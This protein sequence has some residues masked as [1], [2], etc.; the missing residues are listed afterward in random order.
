LLHYYYTP[1]AARG[2]IKGMV[3]KSRSRRWLWRTL[4]ITL[5]LSGYSWWSLARPLPALQPA[6]ATL[7]LPTTTPAGHF[8]W[9]AIGQAAVGIGG[10]DRIVSHGAQKPIAMASTAKLITALAVL[11]EKPLTA[12][13]SGPVLTLTANDVALYHQYAAQ[14]GSVV[15]VA[16]GEQISE[17]QVLQAM[18]LPSSNNLSDSLAIWAFGSLSNYATY[19]NKYL[20]QLGLKHTHVGSDASGLSA[21]STTTATDL[22]RLGQIVMEQPVLKQIVAQPN[23]D[24]PV[25]GTIRNVNQLL[26]RQ[27]I[28][29]IKTGNNDE[30]PGVFLGAATATIGN[31]Q[32]TVIT[33]LL[34]STS[35]WVAM[36]DSLALIASAQNNFAT[37]QALASGSAV[38]NY[39]LPWGGSISAVLPTGLKV[40]VWSGEK[41][42]ATVHL[43]PISVKAHAGQQVGRIDVSASLVSNK[44]TLPAQLSATPSQP[45]TWWRLT[46]P[47]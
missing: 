35:L 17:Y 21:S 5:I 38:G 28:V 14:G 45:S 36:H 18:M 12:D 44:Q 9:P 22:V 10:D 27:D 25:A 37:I 46:H 20:A 47:F 19:A 13:L 29:G 4:L 8:T 34:G 42:Q 23:A 3:K 2:I 24:L 1:L 39:R 11:H 26:G 41:V 40:T 33:A 7:Q 30:D 16:A 31:H 6:Q 15:R 43:Q 32:A